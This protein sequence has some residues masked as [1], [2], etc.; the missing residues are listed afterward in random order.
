MPVNSRLSAADNR[1]E[2]APLLHNHASNTLGSDGGE[3]ETLKQ[4]KAD[5]WFYQIRRW[6]FNHR[7]IIAIC[8]LLLGGFIALCVYFAGTVKAIDDQDAPLRLG[9][10]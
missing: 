2:E 4:R 9:A 5:P 8:L 6:L 1:H 10:F 3:A 7:A